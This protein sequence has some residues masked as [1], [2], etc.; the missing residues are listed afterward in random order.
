MIAIDKT[1]SYLKE[2]IHRYLVNKDLIQRKIDTIDD[3][4][5]DT[6]LTNLRD[7]K[8][9]LYIIVPFLEDSDAALARLKDYELCSLIVYNTRQNLDIVIKNW[10]KLV[11]FKRHFSIYFVNP[12]SKLD[13]RWIIFP[14]THQLVTDKT[15]LK[16]GLEALFITVDPITKEEVERIIAT[17]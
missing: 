3:S 10:D 2:W 4:G 12:F 16:P 6:L 8:K 15:G 14:T 17:G 13:K 5:E 1:I 9:H 7:G 11:K